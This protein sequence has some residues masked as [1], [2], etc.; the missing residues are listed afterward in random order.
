MPIV[1]LRSGDIDN[2]ALL[3]ELAARP[4]PSEEEIDRHAAEDDSASTD[5]ELA[6]MTPVYPP[7]TAAHVRSMRERLGL[8]QFEFAH[9]FGF[10]IDALQQY[11]RGRRTPSGVDS[12]LLRVIEVDPEAVM[13]ALATPLT[14]PAPAP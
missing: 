1:R 5:E 12:T 7:P 8:S 2:T 4:L 13:R 10:A 11:E 9:R 3:A 14:P 6:S